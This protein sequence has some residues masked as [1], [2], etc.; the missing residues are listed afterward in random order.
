[1]RLSDFDLADAGQG[2]SDLLA[3]VRRF[4]DHASAYPREATV[5]ALFAARAS[6]TPDAPAVFHGELT[7]SYAVLE[8]A[9]NRVAHLLV[10]HGVR[11]EDRVAVMLEK[12][13]EMAAAIL[14]IL[15]A[16]AGYVP[17]DFDAPLE[18]MAYLVADTEA[19]VLITE[20][21]S[22]RRVN[23]L[24]WDC[25][26]LDVIL[27]A[28]SRNVA[29][30]PEGRGDMMRE[31]VW[32]EVGRGIFDDIS[33]GG[34]T[35]SY[36]GDWLSR[37]VMDEYGDNIRIKLAPELRTDSRV[38]EIGCASGISMFRL[39]PLAGVYYGTDLS[40]EIL[41]WTERQVRERGVAN[42]RL[43]HLPADEIHRL[44]A[45]DFDLVVINSVVQCF[46]G[47]NY[48]RDVLRKAIDLMAPTG[49]I[50]LGNLWDQD[51]K[52]EFVESLRQFQ[53]AHAG[54]GLRTKVDRSEELFISRRFLEDLRH[55]LPEIVGI[56]T[57]GMLG[58]AES[59]LSAFGYD[60]IL[61]VDRRAARPPA[62]PRAKQQLD[63]RHVEAMPESPLPER[64]GAD[65]LAYV[66]YTS[67]TSG[68]PKGVM[69]PH[70]AIARLVLNTNYVEL[71]A[72]D[73]CLQTGSLAFD[74]STFEI[75]G[76]LLN[77]GA[78]SR[79]PDRV[80]LDSSAMAGLVRRHGITTVWLTSSLFNQ[81]V[82]ND[83]RLFDGLKY[84]LVGGEKLSVGHVN[85]V[86]AAYPALTMIN[87]YGPTENTTFTTCH[88]IE[89]LYH[90]DIPIGRPIANTEVLILDAR[91]ALVPV[92]VAG[93]IC[94]GGDGLARGYLNDPAL[95]ATKLVPHPFGRG[96]RLYRTGDLGRWT[97]DG[98]VEFLGRIDDQ[99][100]IRGYR[101]EPSEI[102]ARLREQKDVRDAMVVA[103]E[104]DGTQELVAYLIAR[105]EGLNVLDLRERLKGSLPD[106][107]VPAYFMELDRW[108]LNA[109]GKVDRRALPDP[110]AT[111]EARDRA[112]RPASTATERDLVRI[113]EE[114]LGHGGIGVTDNFF[115]SG[116]HSLKVTKVRALIE[117]RL[118]VVVP[119]T[120]I[121]KAPTI[122]D[123]AAY[124]L[125]N[126]RFGVVWADEAM[127]PMSGT[128]G[129]A[130]VFA[131]PPGT[132]DAV[133]YLQMAELLRPFAVYGFN[134][135]E[136][137]TRIRD[138]ADLVLQADP[139]GPFLLFGYSSGG[140]LAYHV[141]RE[142]EDRGKRVTDIVMVD[143]GRKLQRTP[144]PADQVRQIADEFMSHDSNRPYLTSQ[145]LRE[146]AQRRIELSY[147]F[148]DQATDHH[149]VAANIHVVL[150]E[151][152][153]DEMTGADGRV[154]SA[155]S[156]WADVTTGV[157]KTYQGEG[158]HAHM[159]YQ[160]Y[161]ERNAGVL[162][163]ILAHAVAGR[164][165]I[166]HEASG[167]YTETGSRH[168]LP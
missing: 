138:Y 40:R 27:C 94:A 117:Q 127:I 53:K 92:G 41:G 18:R 133:G 43:R 129:A 19:R 90:D 118:G 139:E 102:E 55:D 5:H 140:N 103:R 124:L 152:A 29:A 73:R 158:D 130:K 51:R 106:Y 71:D 25:P 104:L 166:P 95:T 79:P 6:A 34:W 157:L 84:L 155:V 114:V 153:A 161:L 20:R 37:E 4:N 72:S 42:V 48:L 75:W 88:R 143:S 21:R 76:M 108:P 87:G 81:H 58:S 159:L 66:I 38:L 135:I 50:F 23:R 131:F 148:I 54:E 10:A 116:G 167:D 39:A 46:S 164:K 31:D 36:T 82:D 17:I 96:Q 2:E 113:W 68:Q 13:F 162:H 47:H 78:F 111:R 9:S 85:K 8:A 132:G 112:Y 109:N 33:G 101:V 52:D 142:L 126:A 128:A 120:L 99:V 70:R 149:H 137:E 150:C 119:L 144:F 123:L 60:A 91:G 93:E 65:G 62:A 26:G 35:S 165:S 16:G 67:G 156:A 44:D 125:D 24:Q 12:S 136:A 77:G 59:E 134:F 83:I 146:K 80:V 11:R 151:N 98:S 64:T 147:A 30:E 107:M 115:D 63:L 97:A 3:E 100:K 61:R 7:Y 14:G 32:D 86:R 1:M 69:V 154:I 122:R 22:I 163:D 110:E 168:D 57:S 121:F 89:S 74:A 15:K 28:D 145:I 56:E 45:K 160:P 105:D 49:L 141:A